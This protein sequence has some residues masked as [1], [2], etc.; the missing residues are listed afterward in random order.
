MATGLV[1]TAGGAVAK[2]DEAVGDGGGQHASGGGN[3]V[4]EL[5]IA[6]RSGT[7]D[8]AASAATPTTVADSSLGAVVIPPAAAFADGPVATAPS[9]RSPFCLASAAL[10]RVRTVTQLASAS[11]DSSCWKPP[12]GEVGSMATASAPVAPPTAAWGPAFTWLSERR[13]ASE[14]KAGGAPRRDARYGD[15]VGSA[16]GVAAGSRGCGGGVSAGRAGDLVGGSLSPSSTLPLFGSP[17]SSPPDVSSS[18]ADFS[19]SSLLPQSPTMPASVSAA[20]LRAAKV[21]GG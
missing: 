3:D 11:G 5:T 4:N 7:V 14:D 18:P 10:R 6:A 15:A 20:V 1:A 8:D 9:P 21:F 19:A 13:T 16:P 12:R 2:D 17:A